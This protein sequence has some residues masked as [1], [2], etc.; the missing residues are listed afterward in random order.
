MPGLVAGRSPS[1]SQAT[2]STLRPGEQR[3]GDQEDDPEQQQRPAASGR[4]TGARRDGRAGGALGRAAGGGRP[5]GA[6]AGPRGGAGGRAGPR[7]T[8]GMTRVSSAR[9]WRGTARVASA[10]SGGGVPLPP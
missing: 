3:H 5:D 7:G 4:G 8:V 10:S 9:G 2:L 1:G 6:A